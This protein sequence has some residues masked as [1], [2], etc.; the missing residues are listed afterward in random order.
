LWIGIVHVLVIVVSGL[1]LAK[2]IANWVDGLIFRLGVGPEPMEWTLKVASLK[3]DL[4][5]NGVRPIV[6]TLIIFGGGMALVRIM[7]LSS[8]G[9]VLSGI[10]FFFL[11]QLA[12]LVGRNGRSLNAAGW[13]MILTML[14]VMVTY[15]AFGP[16]GGAR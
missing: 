14:C 15:W 8:L 3:G 2:V 6:T 12:C 5:L 16:G 11:T 13:A 9:A 7:S 1:L 10:W 4:L